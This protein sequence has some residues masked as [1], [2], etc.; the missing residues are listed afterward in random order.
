MVDRFFDIVVLMVLFFALPGKTDNVKMQ[1]A[2]V[3]NMANTARLIPVVQST[4][5]SHFCHLFILAG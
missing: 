1:Q 2:Y 3:Q 5:Y 4:G